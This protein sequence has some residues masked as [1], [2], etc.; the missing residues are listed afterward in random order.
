MFAPL[1]GAV[2][3]DIDRQVGW[4]KR[5]VKRQARHTALI[6]IL[7]GLAALAT[8]GAIVVGLIALQSWLVMQTGPF[9]AHGIIGG[10]LLLVAL[11]LFALAFIRRRPRPVARPQLQMARPAQCQLGRSCGMLTARGRDVGAVL[12]AE[13]VARPFV[14]VAAHPAL[15]GIVVPNDAMIL[16]HVVG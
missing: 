7:A 13:G 4:A 15:R 12:I 3:A 1:L 5:E 11:I 10:G 6:G 16:V 8:L 2:R 14:C 9:V